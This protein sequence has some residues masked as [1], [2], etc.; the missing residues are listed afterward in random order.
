MTDDS[1]MN[2]LG[3]QW[4]L[5]SGPTTMDEIQLLMKEKVLNATNY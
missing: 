5:Q 3:L 2:A 4:D 1:L